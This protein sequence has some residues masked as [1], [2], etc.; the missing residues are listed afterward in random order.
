MRIPRYLFGKI[1]N[2]LRLQFNTKQSSSTKL[3]LSSVTYISAT[4]YLSSCFPI[5]IRHKRGN[6]YLIKIIALFFTIRRSRSGSR[7]KCSL[8]GVK[9][10]SSVL[11]K[12]NFTFHLLRN[13][14][15]LN[16]KS[17]RLADCK[18]LTSVSLDVVFLHRV[19][20]IL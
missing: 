12:W 2:K 14:K 8:K 3:Q 13:F 18:R 11:S 16:K 10:F 1:S 19:N 15:H 7:T 17:A 20:K 5:F 6:I 9:G 4:P